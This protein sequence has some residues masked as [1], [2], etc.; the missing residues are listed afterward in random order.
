MKVPT[1]YRAAE[2][3]AIAGAALSAVSDI[4]LTDGIVL[5][6]ACVYAG[7]ALTTLTYAIVT[8]IQKGRREIAQQERRGNGLDSK[9]K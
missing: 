2:I 8:G 5:G 1:T 7:A 4:R 9:F 6:A 3:G